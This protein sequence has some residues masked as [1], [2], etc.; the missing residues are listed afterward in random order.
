MAFGSGE[1]FWQIIS[2]IIGS[3]SG[4]CC[5]NILSGFRNPGGH[6]GDETRV[7]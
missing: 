5:K 2:D 4:P 1:R 7:M 3:E 6:G